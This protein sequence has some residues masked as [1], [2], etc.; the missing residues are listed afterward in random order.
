MTT[1]DNH[2]ELLDIKETINMT[3]KEK[4]EELVK[5]F[6]NLNLEKIKLADYSKIYYPTAK[7]CAL[8]A[9]IE[10]INSNPHSNPFNTDI[11]STMQYWIDVK[12]EINSL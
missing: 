5:K 7:Q 6:M 12:N 10:I 11:Y 2:T 8:I 3:P 9:I 1:Q 4:A